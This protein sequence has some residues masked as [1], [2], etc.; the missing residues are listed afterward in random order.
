VAGLL[1]LWI[2]F[3]TA[4]LPRLGISWW[5]AWVFDNSLTRAVLSYLVPWGLVCLLCYLAYRF[6]PKEKVGGKGPLLGAVVATLA[7]K[8]ATQAFVWY[9]GSGFS[10]YHLVYGSLGSVIAL[11]FWIYLSSSIVL[12]GAHLSAA[13]AQVASRK[14]SEESKS[15]SETG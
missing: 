12:F 14:L 1:L 11:L 9:L 3:T 5:G 8:L 7:W 2:G 4:L 6:M 15:S 10:K 13:V